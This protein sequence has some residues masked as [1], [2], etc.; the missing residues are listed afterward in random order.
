M[1]IG[2]PRS[3]TAWA[4]NWLTTEHSL[5]HH[6]PEIR[7]SMDALDAM[8]SPRT[9]GIASTSAWLSVG[10]VNAHPAKKV[11]LHRDP[12]QIADSIERMGFSPMTFPS[13]EG[14]HGLHLH[15]TALWENP[16]VIWDHLMAS[17]FDAERHALL[18]ELNVQV[19]FDRVT[20]DKAIAAR[21]LAKFG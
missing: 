2:L 5:C 7:F 14:I 8:E 19:D 15:W 3:G 6:D 13:L 20:V 17:P 21:Y 16:R 4:S 9:M 18:K 11:I 10:W 1:V 12:E